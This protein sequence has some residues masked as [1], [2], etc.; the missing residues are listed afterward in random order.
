[1]YS[2]PAV[3]SASQFLLHPVSLL[4][5]LQMLFAIVTFGVLAD[6]GT[7]S[8]IS[9]LNGNKDALHFVVGI[10]VTGF[11]LALGLF[12]LRLVNQ[13]RGG[14]WAGLGPCRAGVADG[15]LS[16]SLHARRSRACL[17]RAAVFCS[18]SI[19]S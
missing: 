3:F 15:P 8:G 16:L 5:L 13:V 14:Q 10:G 12:S 7:I 19:F 18:L 9:I 6:N 11:L 1:M 4:R 2:R 17:P